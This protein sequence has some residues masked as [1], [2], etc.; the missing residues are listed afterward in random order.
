[1]TDFK[2]KRSERASNA[3]LPQK[4]KDLLPCWQYKN[5][6]VKYFMQYVQNSLIIHLTNRLKNIFC[7]N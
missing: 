7:Q 4:F 6:L 2:N 1:M 3:F 5:D